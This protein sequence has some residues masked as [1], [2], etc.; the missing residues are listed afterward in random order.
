MDLQ[1]S[2][3]KMNVNHNLSSF[4]GF[5]IKNKLENIIKSDQTTENLIRVKI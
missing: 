5:R 1:K 4:G 3:D 2:H